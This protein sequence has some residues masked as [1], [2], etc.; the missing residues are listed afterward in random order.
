[1]KSAKKSIYLLNFAI[2]RV[3]FAENLSFRRFPSNKIKFSVI[4]SFSNTPISISMPKI[5]ISG[6]FAHQNEYK[7]SAKG[8]GSAQ[9]QSVS[10]FRKKKLKKSIKNDTRM[11]K[12]LNFPQKKKKKTKLIKILQ[13]N[14]LPFLPKNA[15]KKHKKKLKR[16]FTIFVFFSAKIL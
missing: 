15:P 8:N 6:L 5:R 10:F 4:L 3:F 7:M 14:F 9:Q 11:R 1:M 2:F 16:M 13:A 12:H